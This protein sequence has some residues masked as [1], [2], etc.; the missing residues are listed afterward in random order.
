MKSKGLGDTIDKITT[1]TGIKKVVKWIAGEDCGCLER[2]IALN[3]LFP[4]TTKQNCLVEEEYN[5]LHN[6]MST[7]RQ[8]ISRDEQHKML[9][10]YNRV[11]EANKQSSSCGSCVKELYNTLNKLYKAYE[12]ES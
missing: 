7:H 6:Y 3:K 12:Q 9:E 11:F 8:V 2:Q 4:Y 10:I 5:W 1:A